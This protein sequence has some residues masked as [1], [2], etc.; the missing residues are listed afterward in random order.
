VLEQIEKAILAPEAGVGSSKEGSYVF[1]VDE[2]NLAE[3]RPVRLGQM[4]GA[5]VIFE[6]GV[7]AGDRV[8]VE[9]QFLLAPKTRVAI[10]PDGPA[11]AFPKKQ[12][13]TN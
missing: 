5:Q 6:R 1:V 2:N 3:L 7:A 9:G 11:Q 12:A 8:V 4:H 13:G 10:V